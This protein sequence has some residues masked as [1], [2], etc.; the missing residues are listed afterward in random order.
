[1]PNCAARLEPLTGPERAFR[2]SARELLALSAWK[3]GDIGAAR[4]WTDMITGDPQTPAAA[5]SRA[6]VLSELHCRERQGLSRTE[7]MSTRKP[8][9]LVW[10]G[11]ALASG[12]MLGACTPGGQFDPTEVL[13]SDMFSTKKKLSGEREPLFPNGV[14]GAE[15]GVPPDLVKG[16]QPPPEQQAVDNAAPAPPAPKAVAVAGPAK[17][18]PKPKPKPAVATCAR[19]SAP[20]GLRRAGIRLGIGPR[21]PRK[22]LRRLAEF[23]GISASAGK[24]ASCWAARGTARTVDGV[25]ATDQGKANRRRSRR[26]RLG[27]IRSPAP[28]FTLIAPG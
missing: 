22:P 16:Y 25:A 14:P 9:S 21:L 28:P 23:A 13:S 17:P 4:R 15:T 20:L 11:S 6:E 24:L 18:K 10:I 7:G 12:L 1:M 19:D 2:H 8:S 27:R 26:N 3:E 5:R